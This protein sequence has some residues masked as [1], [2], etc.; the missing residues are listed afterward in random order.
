MEKPLALL[1]EQTVLVLKIIS[2][3][4]LKKINAKTVIKKPRI[5]AFSLYSK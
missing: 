4:N 5:C 1:Q 2:N 3:V